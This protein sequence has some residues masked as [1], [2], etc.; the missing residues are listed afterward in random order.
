MILNVGSSVPIC[1]PVSVCAIQSVTLDGPTIIHF[2]TVVVCSGAEEESP[3]ISFLNNEH[4][5]MACS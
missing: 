1:P 3:L 4:E 5:S 2:Q